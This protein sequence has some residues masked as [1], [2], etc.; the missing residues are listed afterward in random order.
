MTI[1]TQMSRRNMKT[2][3]SASLHRRPPIR[4][5]EASVGVD[6]IWSKVFGVHILVVKDDEGVTEALSEIG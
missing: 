5:A 3:W 2:W 1:I 4:A 6:G